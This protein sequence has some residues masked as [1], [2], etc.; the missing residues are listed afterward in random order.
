MMRRSLALLLL[1]TLL[2]LSVLAEDEVIEPAEPVPDYVT[3]L[4][5]VA[6]EEVGYTEGAHGYTK[7][8]EWSGDPYTQWCAEF[9]CWCVAM[10]DIRYGTE[11]LT[12]VYPLYSGSNSGRSWFIE[13]GRYITRNGKL[14]DWGAMWLN[15]ASENLK[16]G[17]YIP[18]PGDW[19]FFTWDSDDDTDHVAM[20]EYC[21]RSAD[22]SVT[23]HVIEGNNPHA[24]ARNTYAL[25]YSRILGYGT[26]HDMAG[27]TMR[28]G[29]S[30]AK[31]TQLQEKLVSLGLLNASAADGTYGQQTAAA[32]TAFQT[33][34]GLSVTG[35]ADRV[36]QQTMDHVLDK[37]DYYAPE[38]FLVVDDEDEE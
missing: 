21:T 31:V 4:L 13:Q 6:S 27:V 35:V 16:T 30:G 1:L 28:L 33:Q 38:T 5:Q 12:K 7:Y 14:Q 9:L 17:G 24:V 8:G 32:V 18:Q 36:T 11:L 22:G 10:V 3:L 2:P 25:T 15:G 19:M 26:V 29:N 23:V 37:R 20:V 34:Q